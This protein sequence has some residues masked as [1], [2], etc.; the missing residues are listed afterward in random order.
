VDVSNQF[1]QIR[2]LFTDDR[3]IAVLKQMASPMIFP[4]V[5]HCITRQQAPHEFRD[6]LGSA[7]YQEMNMITHQDPGKDSRSG[8][9]RDLSEA[10]KKV[11]AVFV[12]PKDGLSFSS[13][14]HHVVKGS[15]GI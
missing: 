5:P 2:L 12:L 10:R 8:V 6:P 1:Q 7:D 13:P 3:F 11:L 14:D 15:R 4:I 9:F